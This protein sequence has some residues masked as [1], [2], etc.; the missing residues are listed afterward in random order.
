V[1]V[2]DRVG[3][4]GAGDRR[5]PAGAGSARAV[6]GGRRRPGEFREARG[7]HEGLQG[8][9]VREVLVERG[10]LDAEQAGDPPWAPAAAKKVRSGA[11]RPPASAAQA[12]AP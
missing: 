4:V 9:L 2:G 11:I 12:A 8:G 3:T 5:K 1:R 7:D 6:R 10:R